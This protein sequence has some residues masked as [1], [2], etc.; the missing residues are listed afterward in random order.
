MI[1]SMVIM[2][3]IVPPSRTQTRN[4]SMLG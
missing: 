3:A 1:E 2:P 4:P